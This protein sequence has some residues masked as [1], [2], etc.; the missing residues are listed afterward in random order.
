MAKKVNSSTAGMMM[1][2]NFEGW[3]D[4]PYQDPGGE[5]KAV[6]WGFNLNDP[7]VSS[8]IHPEI[9]SGKRKMTEQEAEPIFQKKY[10]E[11]AKSASSFIGD[12]TFNALSEAQKNVLIDMAYNMGSISEFKKLKAAILKGDYKTAAAELKNSKWYK[13]TGRRAKNHYLQ[14][15]ER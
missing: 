15:Q 6:A 3:R 7:A 10:S 13:Q 11:A 4:A 5:N 8:I 1:T 9:I 2:K 14:I 12:Q